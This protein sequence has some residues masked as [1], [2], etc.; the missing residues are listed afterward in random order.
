MLQRGG[1]PRC[2][3]ED[4]PHHRE[5][6]RYA[7]PA[8][9]QHLVDP[10]GDGG[11]LPSGTVY[12]GRDD[13]VH[14]LVAPLGHRGGDIAVQVVSAVSVGEVGEVGGASEQAVGGGGQPASQIGPHPVRVRPQLEHQ[15]GRCLRRGYAVVRGH[16]LQRHP[17]RAHRLQTSGSLGNPVDELA[18]RLLDVRAEQRDRQRPPRPAA[19]RNSPLDR[20]GQLRQTPAGARTNR[21]HRDAEQLTQPPGVEVESA[22]RRDVEHGER[23]HHRDAGVEHLRQQVEVSGQVGGVDYDDHQVEPVRPAAIDQYVADQRLVG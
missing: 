12:D 17:T 23:G 4:S 8:R 6:D 21:H 15:V 19:G 18:E 2:C 10:V 14:P 7:E 13:V 5:E 22:G 11:P 3:D 16:Q 9:G 1:Q 20:V